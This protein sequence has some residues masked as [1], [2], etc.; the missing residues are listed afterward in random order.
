MPTRT[1]DTAQSKKSKVTPEQK[2][3]CDRLLAL[4]RERVLGRMSQDQF[5]H[6]FDLGNQSNV[7]HYL[8]GRQSLNA[9][10]ALKFAQGLECFVEDFSPRLSREIVELVSLATPDRVRGLQT[11]ASREAAAYWPFPQVPM[12]RIINLRDPDIARVEGAIMVVVAQLDA[13]HRRNARN[14][15]RSAAPTEYIGGPEQV[16]PTKPAHRK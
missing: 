2:A 5:G 16:E 11:R 15:S 1:T 3:E 7:G 12:T 14:G 6:A 13:E 10:A 8:H 9:V 4:Y